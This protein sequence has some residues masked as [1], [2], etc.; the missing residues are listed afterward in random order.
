MPPA[1]EGVPSVYGC[2][3]L[4][5]LSSPNRSYVGSTNNPKRRIRQHNGEIPQGAFRTRLARPWVMDAFVFGFPSRIA[6]LQFE[7][8]WQNPVMTRFLRSPVDS[9]DEDRGPPL[10][11][12]TR[13]ASGSKRR[14]RVSNAPEAQYHVLRA[15]LHSEPFCFW[16]LRVALFTEYAYGLWSFLDARWVEKHGASRWKAA[17]VTGRQLPFAPKVICEFSG[18]DE[19]REPL[20]RSVGIYPSLP[21]AAACSDH[22]AKLARGSKRSL[23]RDECISPEP[24]PH[25]R[26]AE[27]LGL[28]WD[29]LQRAP[30]KTTEYPVYVEHDKAAIAVERALIASRCTKKHRSVAS[31][32]HE[33]A[34]QEADCGLCKQPIVLHDTLSYTFC[35][36]ATITPD[37][38]LHACSDIFHIECLAKHYTQSTR[39]CMPISGNCPN[40]DAPHSWNDTVRRISRRR[41]MYQ[42]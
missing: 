17:R 3:L 39:F 25:A 38:E 28:T 33:L 22:Q 16:D 8:S 19:T 7:W 37:D 42:D 5:S 36:G 4:R 29:A 15:L 23:E 11:V 13:S 24:T 2:Y 10:F 41:D 20:Q 12:S 26:S 31:A 32:C 18:V 30:R 35:P 14:S 34:Q 40:C 9:G 27:A 6:A 21:E 1:P